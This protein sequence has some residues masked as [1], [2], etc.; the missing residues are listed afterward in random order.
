[1]KPAVKKEK[2]I[3]KKENEKAKKDEAVPELRKRQASRTSARINASKRLKKSKSED[4]S[5]ATD[6][7]N[8]VAA[9]DLAPFF[10]SRPAQSMESIDLTQDDD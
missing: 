9:P 5:M 7:S 4:L 10:T 6:V 8:I 3:V 2:P 1:M